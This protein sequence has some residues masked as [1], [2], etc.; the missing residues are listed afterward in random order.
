MKSFLLNTLSYQNWNKN[1]FYRCCVKCLA[2]IL[3]CTNSK[4][5]KNVFFKCEV[6][7]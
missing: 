2:F 7:C 4:I 3:T 6:Q 1:K 5:N